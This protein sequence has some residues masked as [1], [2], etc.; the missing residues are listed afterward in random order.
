MKYIMEQNDSNGTQNQEIPKK[1]NES[2]ELNELNITDTEKTEKLEKTASTFAIILVLSL[3]AI[4]IITA[5]YTNSISFLAELLDSILDI[6]IVVITL[7]SLKISR[8]PA[9]ADHMFGYQKVNSF[10]GMVNSVITIGLFIFVIYRSIST[11][12]ESYVLGDGYQVSNPLIVMGSL[13]VVVVVNYSLS[14]KVI[15]AGEKLDNASIKATGVNFRADLYRNFAVIGGMI[16]AQFD[17]GF[18]DPI[19]ALFFS[20][21]AIYQAGA[22]IAQSFNELIDYSAIDPQKISDLRD[23]IEHIA[24]LESVK[25]IAIRTAGNQMNANLLISMKE[26]VTAFGI[27]DEMQLIKEK[28]AG[29][30]PNYRHNVLIEVEYAPKNH[31]RER[32]LKVLDTV[33]DIA[34]QH[35]MNENVHEISVD[36]LNEQ[37]IIQ[38]D[39]FLPGNEP[40]EMV[41][42]NVSAF[43]HDVKDSIAE[44]Y[45]DR[46]VEVIS[47]LEPIKKRYK[48]HDHHAVFEEPDIKES[49]ES[50][51]QHQTEEIGKIKQ[52]AINNIISEPDGV[53]LTID[54]AVSKGINVEDAHMIAEIVELR[55]RLEFEDIRRCVIHTKSIDA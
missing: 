32:Y 27:Q 6:L 46:T 24:Q 48:I 43:E 5:F 17:F 26:N 45:D 4:K 50:F 23:E 36:V 53:Y 54:V 38:F 15:E 34:Q 11:L 13:V 52:I 41:Y 35:E 25:D 39:V 33:R 20:G 3:F 21:L 18:I 14:Y 22:V 49:I 51:L 40:L 28:M 19:L 9:D 10:A 1:S 30:F 31:H 8:Q 47:H 55:L 29:A 7:V 12:I 42:G 16:F 44:M 2:K 37:V